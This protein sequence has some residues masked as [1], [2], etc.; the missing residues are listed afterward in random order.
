MNLGI[1]S[2]DNNLI[3]TKQPGRDRHLKLTLYQD[4]DSNAKMDMVQNK[5][6]QFGE[7][8]G[9]LFLTLRDNAGPQSKAIP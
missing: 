9:R 6:P 3:I 1:I 8:V 2:Y 5:Y 7:S 4:E